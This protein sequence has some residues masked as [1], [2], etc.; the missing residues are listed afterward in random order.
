MKDLLEIYRK[1]IVITLTLAVK[2]KLEL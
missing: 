2:K 1:H